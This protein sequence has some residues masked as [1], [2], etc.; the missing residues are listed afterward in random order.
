MSEETNILHG[1]PEIMRFQNLSV[2]QLLLSKIA[3]HGARIA[4]VNLY[5]Y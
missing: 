4:Q 2:G 5:I 3:L 1:G